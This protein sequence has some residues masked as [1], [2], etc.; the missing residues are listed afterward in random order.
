MLGEAAKL[1]PPT[2]FCTTSSHIFC[3]QSQFL[4]TVSVFEESS[5]EETSIFE[6]ILLGEIPADIVY[7]DEE[8]LAFRDVAPKAPVHVLVIPKKT[9]AQAK[10]KD[11]SELPSLDTESVGRFFQK[12]AR[13]AAQLGLEEYRIVS[14]CGAGAG[15]SVFYFHLHILGGRT[16]SGF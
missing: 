11:F 3:G 2:R 5:M 8:V 13:I 7:E 15:Q 10:V 6:R 16:I 1:L 9:E 14:N 12:T 4:I